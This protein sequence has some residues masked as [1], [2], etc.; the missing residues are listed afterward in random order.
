MYKLLYLAGAKLC[1][2]IILVVTISRTF[3]F[4]DDALFLNDNKAIPGMPSRTARNITKACVIS[5][6]TP[7]LYPKSWTSPLSASH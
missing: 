6:T 4:T 2:S 3:E 7:D 5:V 1:I